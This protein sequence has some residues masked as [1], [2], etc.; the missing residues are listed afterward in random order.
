MAEAADILQRQLDAAERKI[1]DLEGDNQKQRDEIRDRTAERDALQT[2]AN[3]LGGKVPKEGQRVL[4]K[5]ESDRYEAFMQ[6][7]GEGVKGDPEKLTGV[8][9][10]AA[11]DRADLV[12]T[13]NRDALN[14]LGLKPS[15]LN[16]RQFDGVVITATKDGDTVSATVNEGDVEK[17]WTDWV[18]EKGLES[19]LNDV[20]LTPQAPRP[21]TPTGVGTRVP[22]DNM[23][24]AEE[25]AES[26][27]N[28]PKYSI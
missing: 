17:S 9:N 1:K 18:K 27:R 8:L 5:A 4:S 15:V 28:D 11:R 2:Q 6:V 19:D 7:G 16:W 20:G 3:D 26:Q 12:T 23:A 24:T 13:R 14:T 25:I 21:P 10:Q 22:G